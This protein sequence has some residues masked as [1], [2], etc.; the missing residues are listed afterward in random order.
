MKRILPFLLSF[1]LITLAAQISLSRLAHSAESGQEGHGGDL[2]VA[3]FL[4]LGRDLSASLH[5]V[6]KAALPSEN[7]AEEFDNVL[8]K[9]RIVSAERVYLG[10]A[11]VDAINYPWENPPRVVIGRERWLDPRLAR[12]RKQLLILHE[13]LSV[14]GH[15]DRLYQI[16]HSLMLQVGGWEAKQ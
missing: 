14:L 6:A 12:E 4:I 1:L 11:E 10:G 3:D 8:S 5:Q 2:I 13:L 9:A 15:D 16:S 7:F